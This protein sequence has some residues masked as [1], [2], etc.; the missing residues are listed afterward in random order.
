MNLQFK[1]AGDIHRFFSEEGIPYVL[2]GGLALQMWGEPRFTRDVD[3]TILVKP[4]EEKIALKRILS[5]F[6][7]R[8]PDAL[9]FALKNRVC[10]VK[11]EDGCEIDISLGI[12]GY[13]EE[14]MR[15]AVWCKLGEG[16]EVKV[17]SAEDLIIKRC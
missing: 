6:P 13:E 4:D 15:R 16:L 7:P 10:L 9:E 1:A 11:S 2:I 17:C 12:P 5:A 8:I 3:V 14:V